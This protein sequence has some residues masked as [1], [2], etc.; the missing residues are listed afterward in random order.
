MVKNRNSVYY[1]HKLEEKIVILK[2]MFCLR[3]D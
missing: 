3:I 1:V 2:I